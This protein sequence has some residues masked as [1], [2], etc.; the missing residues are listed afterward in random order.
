MLDTMNALVRVGLV[1]LVLTSPASAP[2]IAGAASEPVIPAAV[3]AEEIAQRPEQ[4]TKF[5]GYEIGEERRYVLG[6]PEALGRGETGMWGIRLEEVYDEGTE[7][8]AGVFALGHEW[9][10]E[11]VATEVPYRAILWVQSSGTVRVNAYGFPLEIQYQTV[12]HLAGLGEEAYTI[13]YEY[14]DGRYEKRTTVTGSRWRDGVGVR[15]HKH[16]DRD[17]PA[18]L[19]AYLPAPPG[20]LDRQVMTFNSA[21]M[22]QPPQPRSAASP[23]GQPVTMPT[24]NK[25]VDN[26]DCEESLFINPGLLSL[27]MPAFWEAK[28]DR[29]FLFFTPIGPVGDRETRLSVGPPVGS[30]GTPPGTPPPPGG[31]QG[32]PGSTGGMPGGMLMP[33]AITPST[34]HEIET[35]RFNGERVVAQVGTRTRDAWVVEGPDQLAAIYVDDDGVVLRVDLPEF[36]ANASQR[37]I[38]MLWPSEF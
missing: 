32:M 37:W 33:D 14:T 27:A 22:V 4:S 21:A 9:H 15:G 3:L 2:A 1:A 10:A 31:M 25:I 35:L 7:D 34:Y 38:R 26:A 5:L 30:G 8:A 17:L 36:V 24:T 16:L 11:L 6:P 29:E 18:G 13:E 20:C 12:R 19:F 28:G 23:A